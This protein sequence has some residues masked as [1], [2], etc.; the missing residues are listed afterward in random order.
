[1]N[2]SRIASVTVG[3]EDDL[4][5][6]DD[7]D[8]GDKDDERGS[9][10]KDSDTETSDSSSD[11][12]TDEAYFAH[13]SSI[14]NPPPDS[15]LSTKPPKPQPT[16]ENQRLAIRAARPLIEGDELTFNY[17]SFPLPKLEEGWEKR[18]DGVLKWMLG[19]GFVPD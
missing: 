3:C 18:K 8:P 14:S 16:P 2:Y 17:F 7:V 5:H 13:L 19:Y 1:M 15:P 12:S 4:N 9:G 10:E 11:F 6:N